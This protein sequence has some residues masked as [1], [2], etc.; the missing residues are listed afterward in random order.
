LLPSFLRASLPIRGCS[1][2]GSQGEA[3]RAIAPLAQ[4]AR[5]THDPA[6]EMQAAMSKAG[7]GESALEW[8]EGATKRRPP[9]L[10]AFHV[11]GTMLAS[12]DRLDEAIDVTRCGL[13]L[14]PDVL[15]RLKI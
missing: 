6:I 10:R 3:E 2:F 15:V 12:L 8:L 5:R 7:H 11:Y 1:K 4:A 14:M 13:A 9:F